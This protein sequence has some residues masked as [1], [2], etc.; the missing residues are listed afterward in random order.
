MSQTYFYNPMEMFTNTTCSI[1]LINSDI[2]VI[3]KFQNSK[4]DLKDNFVNK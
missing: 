3:F 2:L 1:G 4:I